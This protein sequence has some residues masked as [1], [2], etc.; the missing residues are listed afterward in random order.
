MKKMCGIDEAGRGCIAGP[1]FIAGCILKSEIIGLNDSK[2]LTEK[3]REELFEKIISNSWYKLVNFSNLQIDELG[4]SKCLKYGL[5]ELIEY[6]SQFKC[7]I[8]YDG[9]TSFGVKNLKTLV[10]AD[11]L[12]PEVSAAS[13]LAKVSRDRVM[14]EFDKI[15]PNYGFKQHKGYGCNSHIQNIKKYGYC[16]IHRKTFKIKALEASLFD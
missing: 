4:L 10:K 1:L 5:E 14:K 12:I 16:E 3:K 9:N 6:F 15:Y 11:A 8:L 7:E 13:I 2:K